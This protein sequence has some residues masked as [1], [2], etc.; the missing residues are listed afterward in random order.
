M[1]ARGGLGWGW[2]CHGASV[3]AW[4][5]TGKGFWSYLSAFCACGVLGGEA[6]L[7]EA[8]R[9]PLSWLSYWLSLHHLDET[10][11]KGSMHP[12]SA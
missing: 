7:I 5:K 1:Q 8:R 2:G 11:R 9:A 6:S 12:R 3:A 10:E 4:P